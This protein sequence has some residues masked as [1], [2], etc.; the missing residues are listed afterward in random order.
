MDFADSPARQLRWRFISGLVLVFVIIGGLTLWFFDKTSERIIE[1]LGHSYAERQAQFDRERIVGP[2]NREIALAEKLAD[3][4]T[5]TKWALDEGNE[6]LKRAGLA[7]LASYRRSFRD[8]SFFFVPRRSGNY[9]F[10]DRDN[11]YHGGSITQVIS[12]S[13]PADAWFFACLRDPRTTQLNVDPNVALGVTKVWINVKLMVDNEVV[14]IAGTGIDLGSFTKAV[15]LHPGSQT[16]GILIE[17]GGA[18]QVHPDASLIDFNT[19]AKRVEERKTIYSLLATDAQRERLRASVAALMKGEREVDVMRLDV[20][21]KSQLV[22]ITPIKEIG[23][24][25]LAVVDPTEI[26]SQRD[27]AMLVV[28]LIGSMLATALL[29]AAM[30]ERMVVRPLQQL[31]RGA[32]AIA[33]GDYATR[34]DVVRDDEIGQ[35][36][37][38]F[39]TMAATIEGNTAEL[40]RRVEERTGALRQA[41]AD[42]I[43]ARDAAEAANRAKS[44]FLAN[45]SHEIRTP[46]NG[47]IGMTSLLLDTPLDAEQREF[48]LTINQ[49]AA[50]LMSIINDILDFSKI[51]AGKLDIEIIDFDLPAVVDAA[52]ALLAPRAAEKQLRLVA[53]RAPEV[54]ALLRGDPGHLRQVLLNL[55]GNAIKFTARGEVALDVSL[56][57]NSPDKLRLRFEIRDSGI[58]ITSEQ[59]ARLFQPFTQADSS[60]TRRFG[61]TGL[62]LAISRQLVELMGGTIGVDSVFGAGSLF[63]FELSFAPQAS[64]GAAQ[65]SDPRHGPEQKVGAGDTALFNPDKLLKGL[66]GDVESLLAVLLAASDDLELETRKLSAAI[67][68][69]DFDQA[70]RSAHILCRLAA[71]FGAMPLAAS[72][73]AIEQS[74]ESADRRGLPARMQ[75]FNAARENLSS[76]MDHWLRQ[77]QAAP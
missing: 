72:A 30:L 48:A 29:V 27:F 45:V 14:A 34:V 4:P 38:S 56:L 26:V 65:P 44:D 21:G 11:K 42:L 77:R 20:S 63:W 35:L 40:E 53:R 31:A 46:M 49:S 47:V 2:L 15:V 61:G 9:Y 69:G 75:E 8:G 74:L 16:Y 50:A 60:T 7:G 55:V 5:L 32:G 76:A 64:T 59:L 33:A 25:N 57:E 23:W 62:G 19:H 41:N 37:T 52:I 10:N 28:L 39:N 36:T 6:E 68:T 71:T 12:E 1:G 17:P 67:A 22:A 43:Q 18:I 51:E 73:T 54:P 70:G 13:N 66:G 24:L 3:S 58:G